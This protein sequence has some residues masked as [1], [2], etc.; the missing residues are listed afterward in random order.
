MKKLQGLFAKKEH[1]KP[2]LLSFR[3]FCQYVYEPSQR[4]RALN[5]PEGER[6]EMEHLIKSRGNRAE[7]TS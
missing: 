2:K 5:L 4:I 3:E 7:A 6:L 1:I